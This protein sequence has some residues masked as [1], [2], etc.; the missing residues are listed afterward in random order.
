MVVNS[1]RWETT[2]AIRYNSNLPNPEL[3]KAVLS[4]D[5]VANFPS[6]FTIC[7]TIRAPYVY[8]S[9]KDTLPF[10]L[11]QGKGQIPLSEP[12]VRI[13]ET[14]GRIETTF[15]LRQQWRELENDGKEFHAFSQQ[16]IKGCAAIDSTSGVYLAVADGILVRNLTSR[17]FSHNLK[18]NMPKDL[19]GNVILGVLQIGKNLVP[20]GNMVT[21]VNI[22]STAHTVEWMRQNTVGGTCME[23]GDYLAWQQMNWTLHGQAVIE[24]VDAQEACIGEPVVDITPAKMDFHSCVQLCENIGSRAWSITTSNA[25]MTL[26]KL[27]DRQE[28]FQFWAPID[29]IE[30][31]EWRDHYTRQVA[32]YSLPWHRNNP[33]DGGIYHCA[34]LNKVGL[35]IGLD[36]TKCEDQYGC[37]CENR[38]QFYL[39]LR[40]LCKDSKIDTLYQPK[41]DLTEINLRIIGLHT[42]I[43]Y[44]SVH[45]QWKLSV[46]ERYNIT[47]ASKTSGK[48]V[49]LGR[50]E[51]KITGDH[52]CNEDLKSDSYTV[53][54]KMSGCKDGNFTCNDG[55]CISMDQRCD[56]LPHCSDKSD[57]QG[58]DILVL[59]NGHNM[60]IPPITSENGGKVP[61]S[62][63]TSINIFK[64]VDINEEDYSIEI[65][66]QITLVWKENRATYQNLKNKSS[67]NALTQMDI[68]E[69]WLPKVIYENTDQKDTT[70]L[71]VDWEWETNVEVRRE[72]N[73]TGTGLETVDEA[74]I[75]QGNESSLIMSQTYTHEFQ[76]QYSFVWYPFDTQV[77]KI[78]VKIRDVFPFPLQL[79]I[80]PS[81]QP[82]I[83]LK[84]LALP[85]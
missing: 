84:C 56:Q 45:A 73:F 29:N 60:N 16:W 20:I 13:F 2:H 71:G 9:Y 79:E 54:L 74:Y 33:K 44:D 82:K 18:A 37:I 59:E 31:G 51:W 15:D 50:H 38:P 48:S 53:E 26:K 30:K 10:F 81:P 5:P 27:L 22:F 41:G 58:C 49:T 68:K 8:K 69:L 14:S 28:Y 11:L 6:S 55:Q 34:V 77:K 85:D 42:T 1:S 17:H 7:S 78:V 40:G 61:V 63:N 24:T 3:T 75:F 83:I 36:D 4:Q 21:N 43:E 80:S 39:R 46:A 35:G 76:C 65:Q 57:E 47:G 62:V 25:W 12:S 19:T 70:R 72:G 67:L 23:D 64:L 52:H 66:F 32:N